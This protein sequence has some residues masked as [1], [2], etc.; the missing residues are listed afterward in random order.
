MSMMLAT[1]PKML[2]VTVIV[3]LISLRARAGVGVL[4][5]PHNGPVLFEEDFIH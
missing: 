5:H 3:I 1:M 4:S 2:I